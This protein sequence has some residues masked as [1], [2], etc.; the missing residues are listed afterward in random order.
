MK[1]VLTVIEYPSRSKIKIH[2]LDG[3]PLLF[4][5][6]KATKILINPEEMAAL[7]FIKRDKDE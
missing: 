2:A 4:W 6:Y 1:T 5:T 3:F 7:E